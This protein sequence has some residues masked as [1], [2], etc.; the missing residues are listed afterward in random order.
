MQILLADKLHPEAIQRF[1]ALPGATVHNR[2]QLGPDDLPSS[3]DGVEV[4]VVRSTKVSR[5]AIEAGNRLGLI[6]RAGAGVNTIDVE[7]ASARGVYVANCPG[8]NATAVAELTL[9]LL[10]SLD[11]AIPDCVAELR[12]GQWNK[13]RFSKARGIKGRTVG[14]IGTGMIGREVI[15]RLAA[16]E[17]K[18]LAWSRSL[19]DAAAQ[20]L[21]VE[22]CSDIAELARRSD[23]VTVHVALTSD[24]RGMLG[25]DFFTALSDK[26]FFLN[27]SRAEVVD[28][29]ALARALERGV[30]AGLDVFDGEPSGKS[31]PFD[32]ELARHPNCY[33]THH[34]GAS[35]DQSEHATGLEAAR[36]AA[37]FAGGEPIPNCVNLRPAPTDGYA[38]VVRHEDRVG[39]LAGI[40]TSLKEAGLN[41]Q[42]ME[43]LIFSGAR[44]ACARITL[45]NQVPEDVVKRL[46]ACEG[47]LH[48]RATGVARQT[49]EV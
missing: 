28:S 47:V 48:V 38:L 34:I 42:E 20:E 12:R 15:R 46:C 16:F 5:A 18:V 11:R 32:N 43:N 44:A 36:I 35:T 29:A 7:A 13:A 41:V 27:T 23:V 4:L 2:P 8:K 31:G 6:I 33:G 39:V 22:R 14:V 21:G 1:Q 17:V 10:L 24:T 37:A 3:L 40:F 30:R 26:A 25:D 45:D 19:T 49:V 9:G